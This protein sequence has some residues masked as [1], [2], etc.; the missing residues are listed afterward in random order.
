MTL[1]V[2]LALYVVFGTLFG[3]ATHSHR[4]LFSEGHTKRS[5]SDDKDPLQSLFA[6]TLLC[7]ALWP[8]MLLTGMFSWWVKRPR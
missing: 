5:A 2:A 7:S 3:V 6:W 1:T 4:H 8:L